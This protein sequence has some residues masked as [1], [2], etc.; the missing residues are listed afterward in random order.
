M[1]MKKQNKFTI[2]SI[3][4]A[5]ALILALTVYAWVEVITGVDISGIKVKPKI[6]RASCRERVCLSV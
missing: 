1:N 5:C 4:L 6:G 3:T 2:I